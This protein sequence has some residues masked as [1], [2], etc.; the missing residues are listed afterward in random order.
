MERKHK[1]KCQTCKRTF[2]WNK[3]GLIRH[4]EEDHN[5]KVN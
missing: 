3:N 2:S 4:I 5:G 1:F